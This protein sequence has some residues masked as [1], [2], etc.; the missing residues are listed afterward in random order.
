VLVVEQD[1]GG[2]DDV[3]DVL[4]SQADLA[5]GLETGLQVGV[6]LLGQGADR[7]DDLVELALIGGEL[8]ALGLLVRQAEGVRGALV[9]GVGDRQQSVVRGGVEGGQQAVV[10]G[11]GD[12]VLASGARG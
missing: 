8:A 12:V 2:S 10:A 5:Q 1:Q 6:G 3:A 4:G 11:A 7:A 9:T